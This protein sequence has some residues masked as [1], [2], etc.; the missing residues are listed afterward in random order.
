MLFRPVPQLPD[1]TP[2]ESVCL[3]TRIHNA[4]NFGGLKTVGDIRATSDVVLL[5]FPDLGRRSVSHLRETLGRE[6]RVSMRDPM[7]ITNE[8]GRT[9]R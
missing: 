6:E 7:H 9:G 5:S 1:D 8:N 4:L 3:P 2:L